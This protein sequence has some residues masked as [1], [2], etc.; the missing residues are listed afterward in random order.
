[1]LL[2]IDKYYQAVSYFNKIIK[3]KTKLNHDTSYYLE[4]VGKIY[5]DKLYEAKEALKKFK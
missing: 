5:M 4:I 1:M 3:L 2:E